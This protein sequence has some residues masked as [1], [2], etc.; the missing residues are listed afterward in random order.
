MNEKRCKQDDC[1][2]CQLN[3]K[4]NCKSRDI[5]YEIKCVGSNE[6]NCGEA[7]IGESAR[8]LGERI[9]EHISKY[10]KED[11]NSMLFKHMKERHGG[12]KNELSIEKLATC[13]GDAMLRQVTEAVFIS[14]MAPSLNSKEEWG[15]TNV[16]RLRR[17]NNNYFDHSFTFIMFVR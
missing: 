16:P 8:S 3:P 10:E 9:N 5:V 11:K 4:D 13:P 1:R 17:N 14:E 15:K 12:T 6:E 2:T 7:Y